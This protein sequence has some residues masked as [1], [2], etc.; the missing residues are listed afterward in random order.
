MNE[1]SFRKFNSVELD[2][3][4]SIC[5][6]MKEKKSDIIQ[7]SFSEIKQIAKLKM[8]YT[9]E[10]FSKILKSM[11]KKLI[12]LS[13]SLEDEKEYLEFV[14]FTKY[15]INKRSKFSTERVFV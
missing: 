9:I 10:D 15:Q 5:Y 8:N 2:L 11:Y 7:L 6:Q 14:L 1:I 13:F 12:G 4:F 3:F